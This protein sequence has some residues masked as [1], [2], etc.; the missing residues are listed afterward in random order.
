MTLS[1]ITLS[2]FLIMIIA[3]LLFAVQQ[4]KQP[5]IDKNKDDDDDDQGKAVEGTHFM[6]G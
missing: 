3:P 6:K 4:N 2:A 1:I 5:V